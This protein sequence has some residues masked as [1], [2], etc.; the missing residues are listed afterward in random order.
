MHYQAF[1]KT[2][3]ASAISLLIIKDVTAQPAFTCS[4]SI[5]KT[6]QQC[7][8]SIQSDQVQVDFEKVNTGWECYSS[9]IALTVISA[10]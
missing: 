5:M 3:L 10:I 2:K 9:T 6:L 4:K 8:K 1:L 7:V